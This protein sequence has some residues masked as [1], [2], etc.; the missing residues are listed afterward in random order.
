MVLQTTYE[1]QSEMACAKFMKQSSIKQ[2]LLALLGFIVLATP[3][4][5]M[6]Q[7]S[8][9][10]GYT[11]NGGVNII[12][13]GY[14]GFGGAVS[15]PDSI[16]GLP[17]AFIN[18]TAFYGKSN[19]TSI[20]FP[21]SVQS[22]PAGSF[23]YCAS[24][25]EITV[26]PLNPIFSSVDGVLFNKKQTTLLEYPMG[27]AGNYTIPN[28]VIRIASW[29]FNACVN[30]TSVTIPQGVK[31][32]GQGA[33]DTSTSLTSITIPSTVTNIDIQGF[34][35]CYALTNIL[36]M[37]NAPTVGLFAFNVDFPSPGKTI[38]YLPGSTGWGTSL[39]GIATVV[40]A[41]TTANPAIQADQFGFD[42]GGPTGMT[43]VIE[44][45]VDLGGGG[46]IPLQTNVLAGGL[47]HF[48]D[49]TW[50]TF[51]SRLYRIRSIIGP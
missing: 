13:T 22:I 41:A 36:F 18:Q 39:D 21:S 37:G 45:S 4:I 10:F 46:W 31:N 19:I 7:Q 28:G 6:A 48:S 12:I 33:F 2:I 35:D 30:L 26:D 40:W 5:G 20:A 51:P 24:L 44:A 23:A 32:I 11:V 8:G 25:S 27:K 3:M 42:I 34:H 16:N 38:Y 47:I 1:K 15:I 43:I 17:V 9:D 49:P 14:A 50:V 29:A